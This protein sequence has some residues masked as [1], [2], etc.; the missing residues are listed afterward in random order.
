MR[1]EL[2]AAFDEFVQTANANTNST[3]RAGHNMFSDW[4]KEEKDQL[5][6]LKNMPLPEFD[7]EVVEEDISNLA[8]AWNWCDSTNNKCTP[9]KDQG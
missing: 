1:K 8:T 3:Y 5:L 4:T 6:G 7:E 9:V 2:F